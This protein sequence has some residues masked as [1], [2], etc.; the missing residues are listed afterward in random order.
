MPDTGS[1]WNLPYPSDTALVR[2][3]P[4]Q[5]E[6]LAVATA[7]GLNVTKTAA[8]V[9]S[10]TFNTARIPNLAASKITSGTFALDRIPYRLDSGVVTGNVPAGTV[11][12]TTVTFTSGRFTVAPVVVAQ[13]HGESI[14]ERSFNRAVS[15]STATTTSFTLTRANSDDSSRSIPASWIAVQS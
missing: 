15:V 4:D 6:D 1:P 3:A 11:S 14:L 9:T 13:K 5:F 12:Q 10:G 8:N 7:A 2:D